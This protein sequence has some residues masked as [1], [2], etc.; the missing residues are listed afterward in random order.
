MEDTNISSN[1]KDEYFDEYIKPCKVLF[2][3]TDN[4]INKKNSEDLICPICYQ[5]F[6]N[7]ISCSDKFNS[8]SLLSKMYR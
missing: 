2:Y 6:I 5:I 8:H 4:L 3:T 1:E 7:P